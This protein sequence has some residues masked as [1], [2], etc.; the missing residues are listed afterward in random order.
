MRRWF[1]I[2]TLALLAVVVTM[3]ANAQGSTKKQVQGY[4]AG[5]YVLSE[6]DT[7]NYFNDGWQISGGAILRPAPDKPLALRFDLGYNWFGANNQLVNS[8]QAAGFRVDDGDMSLGTLTAEL[9]WEFG[10]NGG[11]GGFVG[12]GFGGMHR[13]AQLTTTVTQAGYICDPWWG[14]CY[15]GYVTGDAVAGSDSLTKLEYSVTAGVTFPVGNGDMYVEARYHWM[16]T[17]YPS[18]QMLPILLGY[19]F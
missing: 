7:G 13:Y 18:T 4:V 9:L 19:R 5:G 16:D 1:G 6:G 3:P 15:P 10:G 17:S 14:W 12:V 8:A 11:V 2:A